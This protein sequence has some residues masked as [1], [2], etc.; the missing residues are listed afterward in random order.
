V[1]A[2][3]DGHIAL[4]YHPHWL[5]TQR[6]PDKVQLFQKGVELLEFGVAGPDQLT[7]G[8]RDGLVGVAEVRLPTHSS[9]IEAA[10]S[11]TPKKFLKSS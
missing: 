2:G 6:Q 8:N 9:T 7:S 11:R 1:F 10:A 4:P 3:R 5:L